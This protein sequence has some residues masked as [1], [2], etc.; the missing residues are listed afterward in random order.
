MISFYANENFPLP[1]V[2]ELHNLGYNVLTLQDAGLAG[3]AKTDIEVLKYSVKQNRTLLTLNRRHFININLKNPDYKGIIVC[4]FDPNF[5]A[6][7]SRIHH[8]IIG[9]KDLSNMLIRINRPQS[10]KI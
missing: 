8:A 9:K 7:A 4:T 2:Q 10:N 5:K 6:L 1:A 3:Q